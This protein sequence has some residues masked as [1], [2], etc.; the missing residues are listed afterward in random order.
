[1]ISKPTFSTRFPTKQ[2]TLTN[3]DVS[4][5]VSVLSF[6]NLTRFY[7]KIPVAGVE[8]TLQRNTILSRTINKKF[9]L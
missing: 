1:M 9:S 2:K 4:T 3:T 8:P 7:L 6:H 5:F